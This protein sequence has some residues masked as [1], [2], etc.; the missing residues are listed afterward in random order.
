MCKGIGSWLW[1]I[2][3]MLAQK[4]WF[5]NCNSTCKGASLGSWVI[6]FL[7]FSF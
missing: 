2:M 7:Y 5:K 4:G 1:G 6:P 3:V